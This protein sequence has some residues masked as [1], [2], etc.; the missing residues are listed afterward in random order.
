MMDSAW[1]YSGMPAAAPHAT[2]LPITAMPDTGGAAG[3]NSAAAH[4]RRAQLADAN[5]AGLL[6]RPDSRAARPG[7]VPGDPAAGQRALPPDTWPARWRHHDGV[8]LGALPTAVP[9]ARARAR[10]ILREWGLAVLAPDAESIIAELA[11]NAIAAT[12]AE[13]GRDEGHCF[14]R[15]WM[16]GDPSRLLI[17]VWDPALAPPAVGQPGDEDEHG[18]GLLLVAA[19][20]AR[21]RWYYPARPYGG[22]V[23][24]AMLE[25]AQ[26]PGAAADGATAADPGRGG[27]GPRPGGQLAV[28][29]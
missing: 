2:A 7:P 5:A 13:V 8:E 19:L 16:L 27:E 15:L 23:V 25:A 28:G 24:W 20:A 14:V 22:K 21:W 11:A 26:W 1:A 3:V 12:R 17:L 10:E 29:R 18:R 6:S 4:P 9:C